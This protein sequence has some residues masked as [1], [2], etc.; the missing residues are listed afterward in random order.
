MP[1]NGWEKAGFDDSSWK[2]AKA[3]FGDKKNVGTS[4]TSEDLWYRRSFDLKST[5]FDDLFLKLHH[6]DNVD[7]FLNGEKIFAKEGWISLFQS[8]LWQNLKRVVTF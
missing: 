2:T 4:W 7:V 8:Q 1:D 3:P 5:S 6:D